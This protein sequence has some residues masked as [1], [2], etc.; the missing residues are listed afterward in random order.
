[1]NNG[2]DFN[3]IG[4][5]AINDPVCPVKHLTDRRPAKFRHDTP[6]ERKIVEPPDSG[7]ESADHDGSIAG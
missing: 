7:H 6:G 3:L 5:D 1:M 4:R 2:E